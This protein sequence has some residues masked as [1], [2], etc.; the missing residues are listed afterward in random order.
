MTTP[1][2]IPSL[3]TALDDYVA[4]IKT[5]TDATSSKSKLLP[6]DI[7]FHRSLDRNFRTQLDLTSSRVLRL[8]NKLLQ[9]AETLNS[10]DAKASGT[11]KTMDRD[12]EQG[13]RDEADVVDRFHSI[14]VDIVDPLLEHV[15]CDA[16]ILS[17]L[18]TNVLSRRTIV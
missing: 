14:V 2:A 9:L 13:L 17:L 1:L 18:H 15:V 3:D 4:L 12:E 5:Q 11:R 10:T 7:P 6:E 16:R 8:T